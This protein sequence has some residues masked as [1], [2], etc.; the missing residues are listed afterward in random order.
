MRRNSS[1]AAKREPRTLVLLALGVAAA[2]FHLVPQFLPP[3]PSSEFLPPA[4][5]GEEGRPNPTVS[6]AAEQI[7]QGR[8]LSSSEPPAAALF[9]FAPIPVNRA[10]A[11]LL[12]TVDGIGPVLARRIIE[13]RN[14]HGQ[15]RSAMDLLD[16]RGIGPKK[17][18]RITPQIT[19]E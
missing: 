18:A 11:E 3:G 10:D 5:P 2:L 17:L 12:A 19:F 4:R 1:T 15:F 14:H 9:T 16:V 13:W 7:E 6:P 8:G